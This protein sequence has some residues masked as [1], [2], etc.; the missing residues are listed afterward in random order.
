M[1]DVKIDLQNMVLGE[2]SKAKK[3]DMTI[4]KVLTTVSMQ[5]RVSGLCER[6]IS[7]YN[8]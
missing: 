5:M 2:N 7:D 6:T 4:E 3:K 1:F 8:L